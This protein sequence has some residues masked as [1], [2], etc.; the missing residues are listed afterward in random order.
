MNIDNHGVHRVGERLIASATKWAVLP[1]MTSGGKR[2]LSTNSIGSSFGEHKMNRTL[3]EWFITSVAKRLFV[4]RPTRCN[5]CWDILWHVL[6]ISY[7]TPMT[8]L[9]AAS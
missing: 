2:K 6:S 1:M 8:T 5:N 3:H 4:G 7:V 9:R